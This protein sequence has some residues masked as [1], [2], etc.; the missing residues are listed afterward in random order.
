MERG[1]ATAAVA[2]SDTA[3]DR[4]RRPRARL[5]VL[6]LGALRPFAGL[7]LAR[8]SLPALWLPRSSP[9]ALG[10]LDFRL[11]ALRLRCFWRRLDSACATGTTVGE[12]DPVEEP[13]RESSPLS[14]ELGSSSPDPPEL[15]SPSSSLFTGT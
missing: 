14:C 8:S 4:P 12:T 3:Q 2:R 7:C 1:R 5:F 10:W 13:E 15:D 11:A 6:C 9:P